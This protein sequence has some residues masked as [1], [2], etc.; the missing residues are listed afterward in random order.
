MKN[1][2]FT[3]IL[4]DCFSFD[5]S[6]LWDKGII[7]L[8]GLLSSAMWKNLL[9][10]WKSAFHPIKKGG[11][12]FHFFLLKTKILV[13]NGGWE[14]GGKCGNLFFYNPVAFS[15]WAICIKAPEIF[16]PRIS[17]QGT[18]KPQGNAL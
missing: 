8:F 12:F 18:C 7:R 11:F 15:F 9:K 3:G 1:P 16:R 2:R 4:Q 14:F 5:S 17:S 13:E 6:S 10:Q